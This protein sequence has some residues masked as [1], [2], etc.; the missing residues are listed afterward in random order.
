M[1]TVVLT[2]VVVGGSIAV[3]TR[4]A[5]RGELKPATEPVI[6]HRAP[7]EGRGGGWRARR[8]RRA[9][10]DAAAVAP[11][12]PHPGLLTRIRASVTLMAITAL[13]GLAIALGIL[14]GAAFVS[15]TLESAVQ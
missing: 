5:R 1:S 2:L 7:A 4:V 3:A 9:Q 6:P 8:A 15:R 10:Q 12:R 14:A 11:A 13:V